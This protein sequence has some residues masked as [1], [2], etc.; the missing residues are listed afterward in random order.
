MSEKR[1]LVVDDV[2]QMGSLVAAVAEGIGYVVKVVTSGQ[3]F[4][5]TIDDFNPTTVMIDIVMPEMDGLELIRWLRER[6]C[7]AKVL[8]ASADNLNYAKL[9]RNLGKG[10]GLDI[11]VVPKPFVN[12]ELLAALS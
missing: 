5:Q 6:G 3:E 7:D 2:P 4:M 11:S 12:D 1:L 9:G 10:R 8:V